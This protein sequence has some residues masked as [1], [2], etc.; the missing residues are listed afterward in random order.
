MWTV[1]QVLYNSLT[2]KV[3]RSLFSRVFG[4]TLWDLDLSF[5]FGLTPGLWLLKPGTLDP[6][7]ISV[8]PE[9]GMDDK[10]EPV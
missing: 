6:M 1:V 3:D 5:D 4:G 10:A 8:L 7:E 9:T 2:L